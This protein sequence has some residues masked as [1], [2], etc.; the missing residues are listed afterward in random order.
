[1]MFHFRLSGIFYRLE[2]TCKP[3]HSGH[4]KCD[5]MITRVY[6]R[7]SQDVQ[8]HQMTVTRSQHLLWKHQYNQRHHLHNSWHVW[9]DLMCGQVLE[10]NQTVQWSCCLIDT[11]G[12]VL[13]ILAWVHLDL[14][15]THSGRGLV[16]YHG[17]TVFTAE[18]GWSLECWRETLTLIM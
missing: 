1:M 18:C 3:P 11:T 14:K 2:E 7:N 9:S 12:F 10:L 15:H 5:V 4:Q 8:E 17:S 16:C 13:Y 6:K